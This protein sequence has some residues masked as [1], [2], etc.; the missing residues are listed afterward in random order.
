MG[1]WSLNFFVLAEPFSTSKK[2]ANIGSL[3][4]YIQQIPVNQTHF[5]SRFLFFYFIT[6]VYSLGSFS[7]TLPYPPYL[8]LLEPRNLALM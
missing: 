5:A 1:S 3:Y 7:G 6:S 2:T 8:T 4:S